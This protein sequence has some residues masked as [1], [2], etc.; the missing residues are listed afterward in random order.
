MDI[1][2]ECGHL[3]HGLTCTVTKQTYKQNYVTHDPCKCPGQF[4]DRYVDSDN[5]EL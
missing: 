5:P 2:R 1:C 3:W 4:K